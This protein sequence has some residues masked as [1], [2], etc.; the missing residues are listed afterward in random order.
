VQGKYSPDCDDEHSFPRRG[1]LLVAAFAILT[2]CTCAT[3]PAKPPANPTAETRTHQTE[4]TAD[5]QAPIRK[6]TPEM[7]A[8]AGATL[9]RLQPSVKQWIRE[10]ARV[11][12]QRPAPDQAALENAIRARFGKKLAKADVAELELVVLM[13]SFAPQYNS[14]LQSVGEVKAHT[15]AR[16]VIEEAIGKLGDD[17]VP[18]P[19]EGAKADTNAPCTAPGCR[20][21]A[22]TATQVTSLTAQTM[23]PLRYDLPSDFSYAQAQQALQQLRQDL[24]ILNLSSEAER[25]KLQM[26]QQRWSQLMDII[27]NAINAMNNTTSSVV[28]NL[29]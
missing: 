4:Q 15:A 7:R 1:A 16:Q 17:V 14:L 5:A 18:N 22:Q 10:Q 27:S 23:H 9:A 12:S 3:T 6:I 19:A 11:E 20:Y 29:Q 26:A 21:L 13:S 8:R 25:Q 24:N 28:Q 2:L